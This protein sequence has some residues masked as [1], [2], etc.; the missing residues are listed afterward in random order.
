MLEGEMWSFWRPLHSTNPPNRPQ[1]PSY[2]CILHPFLQPALPLFFP[3]VPDFTSFFA[4]R[5]AAVHR[6]GGGVYL[7]TGKL[8]Q[9]HLSGQYRPS[10]H[11]LVP[12]GWDKMPDC[13]I[14]DYTLTHPTILL[15]H[16][17]EIWGLLVGDARA[18]L[19]EIF[20][21]L[22]T[23][24]VRP[25]SL[26]PNPH[27]WSSLGVPQI[28]SAQKT[29]AYLPVSPNTVGALLYKWRQCLRGRSGKSGAFLPIL[30]PGPAL[31]RPPPSR[32][33]ELVAFSRLIYTETSI[34][35]NTCVELIN[36]CEAFHGFNVS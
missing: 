3:A 30:R 13:V 10:R 11:K 32:P 4:T 27:F 2:V 12:S 25:P 33:V 7:P 34:L 36:C 1:D 17:L 35:A 14:T 16:N 21:M 6:S 5:F 8:T 18:S 20:F 15:G 24:H 9:D 31:S 23:C 22:K 19:V 26:P 29:S 28:P